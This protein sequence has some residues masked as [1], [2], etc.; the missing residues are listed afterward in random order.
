LLVK[1]NQIKV[2]KKLRERERERKREKQRELGC[3]DRGSLG[4]ERRRGNS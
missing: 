3:L 1:K 2:E 4:F